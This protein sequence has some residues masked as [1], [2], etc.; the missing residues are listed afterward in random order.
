MKIDRNV[1]NSG[2]VVRLFNSQHGERRLSVKGEAFYRDLTHFEGH[3]NEFPRGDEFYG[4]VVRSSGDSSSLTVSV[5]P[6]VGKFRLAP[7]ATVRLADRNGQPQTQSL[8]I[9]TVKTTS[10]DEVELTLE[11][12]ADY[13]EVNLA[14]HQSDIVTTN[15]NSWPF[16]RRILANYSDEHITVYQAFRR[17]I[18]D[19]AVEQQRFGSCFNSS[20][21]TWIKPSFLWLM[22]RSQWGARVGNERILAITL[23]RAA[24]ET[25]LAVARLT[26][27]TFGLF[28]EDEG[29]FLAAGDK[30]N[31][32]QWDPERDIRGK[33]LARKAIQIGV[34]PEF[35]NIYHNNVLSIRDITDFVK[36]IKAIREKEEAELKLPSEVPYPTPVAL[37]KELEMHQYYPKEEADLMNEVRRSIEMPPVKTR[38]FNWLFRSK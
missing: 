35:H 15:S 26:D 16:K 9:Q 13:D 11:K 31:W 34:A 29:G 23:R 20:R 8:F 25:L 3:F 37:L 24:F 19:Q 28:Y 21:M 36:E 17:E 7:N 14:P 38:A 6:L 32:I 2:N 18:A 22:V 27:A 10:V 12:P 4:R 5:K 1:R 33:R 30:L